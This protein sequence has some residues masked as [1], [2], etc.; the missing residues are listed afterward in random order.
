MRE[1]Q[2]TTE[3]W[4]AIRQATLKKFI[5]FFFFCFDQMNIILQRTLE[6]SVYNDKLP[7]RMFIEVRDHSS[8]IFLLAIK[9]CRF[10][11]LPHWLHLTD[12]VYVSEYHL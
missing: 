1:A 3:E 12:S 6:T 2:R 9:E 4:R 7:R 8:H 10:T 11:A 5:T